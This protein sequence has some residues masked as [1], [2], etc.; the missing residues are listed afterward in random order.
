MQQAH[1]AE[2]SARETTGR[3]TEAV[4]PAEWVRR[5]NPVALGLLFTWTRGT[6]MKQDCI[7]G[8]DIRILAHNS[9]TKVHDMKTIIIFC[10]CD[11]YDFEPV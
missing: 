7:R 10:S 5:S 8:R 3:A 4:G 11:N 6:S 9:T 2:T 1:T